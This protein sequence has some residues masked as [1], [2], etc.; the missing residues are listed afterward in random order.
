MESLI[1]TDTLYFYPY[2]VNST[3]YTTGM[4]C[5]MYIALLHV[6]YHE[7]FASCTVSCLP[8]FLDSSGHAAWAAAT[9]TPRTGKAWAV[10]WGCRPR[11]SSSAGS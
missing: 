6:Q 1:Y 7:G 11:R 9:K 10:S 4:Y 2:T 8:L 3:V 5:M